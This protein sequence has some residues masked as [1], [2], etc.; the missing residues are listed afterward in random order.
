MPE[1]PGDAEA[2]GALQA[3]AAAAVKGACPTCTVTSA[4]LFFHAQIIP[5]AVEFL[6]DLLSADPSGL[7]AIDAVGFHPY[8]VYPPVH[9]PEFN[10]EG[11]RAIGGMSADL[12]A[13]LKHHGLEHLPLAITELGWPVYSSTDETRQ[14]AW[15]TRSVLLAAALGS[16]P[17]CWYNLE[18]G[19]NE[20]A[21]PPEDD[22]GLY[23]HGRTLPGAPIDPKP[24]RDAMAWLAR[25]GAGSTLVGAVADASLHAPDAGRFGL[26]FTGPHGSW[27]V[28][29]S[30]EE[31][32]PASVTAG[33]NLVFVHLGN[34]LTQA[35]TTTAPEPIFLLTQEP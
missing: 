24:A 18:N 33:S 26:E 3:E 11:E 16:D 34:R 13:V 10:A 8:P 5:G 29:W 31:H 25:V 12:R 19:D 35:P 21:F 28:L 1:I 9:A 15:L 22:F 7:A 32:T 27:T 20:G 4:G 6:H 2:F 23:R 17:V 14:S 30:L